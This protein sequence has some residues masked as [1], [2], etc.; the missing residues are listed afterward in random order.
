[1][2]CKKTET[3]AFDIHFDTAELPIDSL[4]LMIK[5]VWVNYATA[6]DY[7]EW[8]KFSDVNKLMAWHDYSRSVDS[9]FLDNV[10]LEKAS[11]I[12]QVRFV[13]DPIQSRG[14]HVIDTFGIVVENPDFGIQ[15]LINKNVMKE[16]HYK[17]TVK[18]TMEQFEAGFDSIRIKPIIEL[19]NFQNK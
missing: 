18:W 17:A 16:M 12:Q 14:I 19:K 3:V 11:V 5:E 6:K 15:T 7:S 9:L 2:S 4:E 1:M 8:K 10:I 13:I